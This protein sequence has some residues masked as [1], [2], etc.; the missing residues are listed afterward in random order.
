MFKIIKKIKNNLK[1]NLIFLLYFNNLN[2]KK[3]KFRKNF[4]YFLKK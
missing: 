1:N 4:F 2:L 3:F